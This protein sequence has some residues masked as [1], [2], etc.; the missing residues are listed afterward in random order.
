MLRIQLNNYRF[1]NSKARFGITLIEV[2]TSIVVAV[3]GVAGVLVLIPF[4]I[5]Q[6]QIGLTLD[7]STTLAENVVSQFEVYGYGR[8]SAYNNNQ[9]LPWINST[10]SLAEIANPTIVP[11]PLVQQN[12]NLASCYWIDPL[13]PANFDPTRFDDVATND[14]FFVPA[15]MIDP[16]AAIAFVNG[17]GFSGGSSYQPLTVQLLDLSSNPLNGIPTPINNALAR[18]LVTTSND[19][20]FA[21]EQ[22][23]VSGNEIDDLSP[24]LPYF[25]I[26]SSRLNDMIDNDGDSAIDEN[27]EQ[28]LRRQ[29]RGETTC[30][31]VAVPRDGLAGGAIEGF[32]FYILIYRERDFTAQMPVAELVVPPMTSLQPKV[33]SGTGTIQLLNSDIAVDNDQW[34]MLVNFDSQAPQVGFFR[35]IGSDEA[36]SRITI[37]GSS[38]FTIP[39]APQRT[40]AIALPNVV[41]VYKR[42]LGLE[43]A[44]TF[45]F[46]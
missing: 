26:D 45:N 32:D 19:L 4:G 3:I 33:I 15:G 21:S 37:V 11:N 20:Q 35:I 46:E 43:T 23:P 14:N 13:S 12:G 25:D 27:D 40:F 36:R 1:S 17:D 38:N 22:D 30:S 29:F 9:C 44:T 34:L 42:Q 16:A 10:F 41:S 39:M 18:R 7:D 6:A 5:R 28:F 2:L 31:A 24:P 8:V